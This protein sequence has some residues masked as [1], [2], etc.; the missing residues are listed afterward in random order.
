[1]NGIVTITVKTETCSGCSGGLD[2]GGVAVYLEV[3]PANQLHLE[4]NSV[5]VNSGEI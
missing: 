5:N 4:I 1:M 2:E 3:R